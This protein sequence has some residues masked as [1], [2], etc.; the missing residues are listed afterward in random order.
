VAISSTPTRAKR[1]KTKMRLTGIA[2]RTS[3]SM[4]TATDVHLTGIR[5]R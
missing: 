4:K 2:K 5:R 3:H 1:M